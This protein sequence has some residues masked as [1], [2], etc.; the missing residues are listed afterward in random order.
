MVHWNSAVV[1]AQA[2][3]LAKVDLA[4][5]V[6]AGHDVH[7]LPGQSG[8]GGVFAVGAVSQEDVALLELIPQAA[9]QPQIMVVQAAGE[10]PHNGPTGQGEEHGQFHDREATAG[11]LGR[12]LGIA[13]LVLGGV[14]QL[15]GGAIH[16][17]DRTAPELAA[18]AGAGIGHLGGAVQ[19]LLQT[20]PGQALPGLHV[21]RVALIDG[22]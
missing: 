5:L 20:R 6:Q 13:L 4:A 21:S 12:G 9:Q 22:A 16:H 8:Q 17:L 18:G 15:H 3:G 10:H 1:L 2:P 7:P 14:G 11:L 19:G